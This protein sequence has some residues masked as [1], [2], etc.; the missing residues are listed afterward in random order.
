MAIRP[1]HAFTQ[2]HCEG[3]A[4]IGD[5]PA[6]GDVGHG[7]IAGIVPK[8]DFVMPAT[9]IA[10]PEIGWPTEAAAPRTAVFA[11][12]VYRLD[13]QRVLADTFLHCWQLA[14]L[15]QVRQLWCLKLLGNFAVSVTTSDPQAFR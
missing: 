2:E 5:F 13:H 15:H 4:I 1:L 8:Q 6:L 9:T 12:L 10:I 14:R 3:A 11:D 7:F